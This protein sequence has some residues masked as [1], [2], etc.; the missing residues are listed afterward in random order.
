MKASD[1]LY[2]YENGAFNEEEPKVVVGITPATRRDIYRK[3]YK[4]DRTPHLEADGRGLE[5]SKIDRSVIL[6]TSKMIPIRV[7]GKFVRTSR[8]SQRVLVEIT[9][10]T[11]IRKRMR[12]I[13]ISVRIPSRIAV[14][15]R[16]VIRSKRI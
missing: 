9:R 11:T 16:H 3:D 10:L 7:L 2:G 8:N 13:L 5:E 1:V 15:I 6:S 14:L 12:T 4:G